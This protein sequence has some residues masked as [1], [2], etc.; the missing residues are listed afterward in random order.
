M[1]KKKENKEQV[2][3]DLYNKK[4]KEKIQYNAKETT[5]FPDF[6]R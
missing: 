1:Y 2:A 4:G 6:T 5:I 3:R